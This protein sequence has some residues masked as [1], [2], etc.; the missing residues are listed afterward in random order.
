[1]SAELEAMGYYKWHWKDYRAD[2]RVQKMPILARGIYRELLDECWS[3]G[4]IPANADELADIVDCEVE[5]ILDSWKYLA[6]CFCIVETDSF[7][8]ELPSKSQ[9]SLANASHS[10]ANSSKIYLHSKKMDEQRTGND[11]LRVKR[12]LAGKKGGEAKA[13]NAKKSIELENNDLANASNCQEVSSK[14]HIEEKRREENNERD[15]AREKN[16]EIQ[17]FSSSGYPTE[18]EFVGFGLT[19]Y[20][21]KGLTREEWESAFLDYNASGWKKNNGVPIANWKSD[22]GYKADRI[23]A[24]RVKVTQKKTAQETHA[25]KMEALAGRVLNGMLER[26]EIDAIPAGI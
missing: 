7:L 24:N 12:A 26:G 9:N 23:I 1:M 8:L 17:K 10:L 14:C 25:E 13:A 16:F 21:H 3:K 11:S 22:M 6:K 19:Q 2:R 4:F 5:E 20:G 18:D 15:N